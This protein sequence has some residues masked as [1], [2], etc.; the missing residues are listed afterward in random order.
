M[1]IKIEWTIL[2]W[3]FL[4]ALLGSVAGVALFSVFTYFEIM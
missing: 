1:K 2:L 3:V 4:G